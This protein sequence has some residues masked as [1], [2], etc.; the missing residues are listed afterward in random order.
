MSRLTRRLYWQWLAQNGAVKAATSPV[1]GMG[2]VTP[3]EA[4]QGPAKPSERGHPALPDQDATSRPAKRYSFIS[5]GKDF[6][7]GS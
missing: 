6:N 5:Q 7:R 3:M 4:Q 1:G 2:V